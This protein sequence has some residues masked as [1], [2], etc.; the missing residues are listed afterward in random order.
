MLH[1]V[2]WY[3]EVLR[4][5]AEF[6]GRARRREFWHFTL[7]NSLLVTALVLVDL[8]F[9]LVHY[10]SGFAFLSGFYSLAVLVPALAVSVRR[11]HD[12]DR[13]AWWLLIAFVPL[14]G[15][16]ALIYFYTL[17]SSPGANRYGPNPKGVIREPP[18]TLEA[19]W[20]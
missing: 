9:D 7:V 19:P 8:R 2:N 5:Y 15:A 10:P 6:G 13:S 11:L 20:N 4:K 12:T 1:R 14:A 18:V 16:L 17:D 3:R